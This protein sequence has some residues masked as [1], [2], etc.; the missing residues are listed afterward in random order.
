[1]KRDMPGV[2][3]FLEKN[4]LNAGPVAAQIREWAEDAL[5]WNAMCALDPMDLAVEITGSESASAFQRGVKYRIDR[6]LGWI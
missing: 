4:G 6:K 5:Y 2:E 1:M 3:M